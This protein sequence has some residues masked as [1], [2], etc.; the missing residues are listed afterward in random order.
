[1]GPVN[2]TR[3]AIGV[4]DPSSL[5]PARNAFQKAFKTKFF[6]SGA[7]ALSLHGSSPAVV[8]ACLAALA[9]HVNMLT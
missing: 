4:V 2:T 7:A 1:M 5:R 9:V 3:E 8:L 6:D